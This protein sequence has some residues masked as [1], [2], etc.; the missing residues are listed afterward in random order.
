M[1]LIHCILVVNKIIPGQFLRESAFYQ[2][3]IVTP[4]LNHIME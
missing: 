3:K 2:K 4:E 1:V